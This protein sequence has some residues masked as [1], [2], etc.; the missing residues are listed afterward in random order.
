[1]SAAQYVVMIFEI[2]KLCLDLPCCAKVKST[3]F[4]GVLELAYNTTVVSAGGAGAQSAAAFGSAIKYAPVKH[5][6]WGA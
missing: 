3:P 4:Q 6:L 5:P 2:P 1:M